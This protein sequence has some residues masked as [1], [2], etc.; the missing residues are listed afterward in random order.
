[1]RNLFFS[2]LTAAVLIVIGAPGIHAQ[3]SDQQVK[4]AMRLIDLGNTREA[5]DN[6]HALIVQEPKNAEAHA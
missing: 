3:A 1:M 6:L 5:I 2:V 4:S